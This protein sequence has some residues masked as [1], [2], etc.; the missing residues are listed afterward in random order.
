MK[1][2]ILFLATASALRL[3]MIDETYHQEIDEDVATHMTVLAGDIAELSEDQSRGIYASQIKKVA[4]EMVHLNTVNEDA[5]KDLPD[6]KVQ[7][8]HMALLE[9]TMR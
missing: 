4:D 3:Q 5:K 1:A 6:M 7:I 2:I 8:E 9:K